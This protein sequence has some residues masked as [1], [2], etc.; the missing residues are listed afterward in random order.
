MLCIQGEF[1]GLSINKKVDDDWVDQKNVNVFNP[2]QA[3]N[4]GWADGILGC[5]KPM[6][7]VINKVTTGDKSI[8][9]MR[10]ICIYWFMYM[11][12][13]VYMHIYTY[14]ILLMYS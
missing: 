9:G 3:T 12:M 6:F 8:Q 4:R 5:L 7:S 14:I 2:V 11:Y 13:Y 1:E 10:T